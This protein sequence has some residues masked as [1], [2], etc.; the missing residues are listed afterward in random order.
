MASSILLVLVATLIAWA[1]RYLLQLQERV[2]DRA[3]GARYGCRPAPRLPNQRAFGLDRLEQMLRADWES[4]LMELFW[5]H[6]RQTGSTL[7]QKFL[8]IK[9]YGTIDPANLK[10]ILTR[11]RGRSARYESPHSGCQKMTCMLDFGIGPRRAIALPMFGDGILTQEGPHWKHSRDLLRP[12]LE[13]KHYEDLEVFRVPVE[14]LIQLLGKRSGTVDLQPLFSRLTLD[15]TTAFLFGESTRSL[16]DASGSAERVFA[17]ALDTAQQWVVKRLRLAALYWLVD[18]RAFRQACRDVHAFVDQLIDRNLSTTPERHSFLHAAA[19]TTSDRSA[20]RAQAVNILVAGRDTTASLLSWTLLRTE[21]AATRTAPS[22]LSRNDLKGM[23]YLQN[24]L[25]ESMLPTPNFPASTRVSQLYTALRLYPS[26]PVST[27]TAL[28]T[29]VLP[30]G[31]GPAGTDPVLIP[32]GSSV[33]FSLYSMHRQ[34]QLYGMDAELFRPE[35]WDEDMPWK[36]SANKNSAFLPFSSGPRRCPGADFA[37]T[38]A[39]YILVLLLLNF[40]TLNLPEGE[41]FELV[42]AEKQRTTLVLSIKEGC[43]VE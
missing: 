42:G 14:D 24:V 6:F 15:T 16:S 41:K 18:S 40:P 38:Q 17:T 4:R 2:A 10:T 3:I 36:R 33:A 35:R 30:T 9:A 34:P 25:K 29:T 37:L 23:R 31:G 8:G 27:R 20:L 13:H 11:T 7:E 21:I 39:A 43:K 26:V 19:Q 5:F 1:A 28:K 22:R 12:Q 32:K